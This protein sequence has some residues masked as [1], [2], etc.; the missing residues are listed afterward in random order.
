MMSFYHVAVR[1]FK[2]NILGSIQYTNF[3]LHKIK[4]ANEMTVL[5][6]K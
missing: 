4:Y 5:I 6:S 2:N 3:D 1:K